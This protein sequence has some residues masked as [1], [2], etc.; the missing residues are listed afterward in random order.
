MTRAKGDESKSL[1]RVSLRQNSRREM[2]V[3]SKDYFPEL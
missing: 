1:I 3:T 2:E